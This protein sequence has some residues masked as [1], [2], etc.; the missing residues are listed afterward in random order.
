M[1]AYTDWIDSILAELLLPGDVNGDG[2]VAGDDLTTVITYW[3]QSGLGREFGDLNDN[4]VVDGP[5]YTEVLTYWGTGSPPEPPS[6][7][8]P[9]PA[10]LA[11]LL[12]GGFAIVRRRGIGRGNIAA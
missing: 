1:P 7:A 2:W 8:I 3:G 6:G 5:D 11:L 4:G 9:E 12:L 10:T